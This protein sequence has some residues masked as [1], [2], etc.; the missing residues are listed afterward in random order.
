VTNGVYLPARTEN[1]STR[2][3]R[4]LIL[5]RAGPRTS[6]RVSSDEWLWTADHGLDSPVF[7]SFLAGYLTRGRLDPGAPDRF[8]FYQI[9]HCLGILAWA[10]QGFP[11]YFAQAQWLIE[12]AL[13]GGRLQLA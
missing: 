5:V 2:A 8:A 9:E 13:S 1:R 6:G 7:Q 4:G 10:S 12:Q 11:E 3:C